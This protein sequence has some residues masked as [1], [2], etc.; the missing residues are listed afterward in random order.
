MRKSASG[1][2]LDGKMLLNIA[3]DVV[4]GVV[5]VVRGRVEC[6]KRGGEKEV[7]RNRDEPEP[8]P[9][10]DQTTRPFSVPGIAT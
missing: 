4:L 6:S 7:I 10:T 9:N 2:F 5:N 1:S 3:I 8:V